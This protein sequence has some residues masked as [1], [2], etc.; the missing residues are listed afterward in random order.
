MSK[1]NIETSILLSTQ[2]FKIV[3]EVEYTNFGD[4]ICVEGHPIKYGIEVEDEQGNIYVFG[5]QCIA[6][7]FILKHW[8]LKLEMLDDPDV[9]RAGR[10]LWVIARDGLE[11][12]VDNVPHPEDLDWNFKEL[13]EQLKVI[14]AKAKKTKR[15]QLKELMEKEHM[16]FYVEKF[17][18]NNAEQFDLIRGL[19]EKLKGL[20]ESN[21]LGILNSFYKEFSGSV[22][23]QHRRMKVL[24]DKQK[25]IIKR[26][27]DL[28]ETYD[29][30]KT[31]NADLQSKITKAVNMVD[32]LGDWDREFI[33]SIQSQFYDKGSLSEKQENKLEEILNKGDQYSE[34]IG[35]EM[36][37]WITGQKVGTSDVRGVIK[38]V[39]TIAKSGKAILCT[40]EVNG[41]LY[42]EW[43]PVSQLK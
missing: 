6:K 31:E 13:K 16:K 9:M 5:S 43:V 40:F 7:P 37:S 4:G 38:S 24:S 23:D 18:A 27:I 19:V 17:K 12:F 2:E 22:I 10:Y 42:E 33:F 1:I 34:Y 39:R 25:A 15:V 30:V 35:R 28:K 11:D 14:I 26:I 21:K 3:G 41:Q 32:T 36:S 29:D 8:N 20:K